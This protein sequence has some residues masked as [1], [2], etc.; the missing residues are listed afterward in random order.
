MLQWPVASLAAPRD[1]TVTWACRT[2]CAVSASTTIPAAVQFWPYVIPAV[3]EKHAATTAID[4][5]VE[6]RK[7]GET[8]RNGLRLPSETRSGHEIKWGQGLC[9]AAELPLGVRGFSLQKPAQAEPTGRCRSNDP[10]WRRDRLGACRRRYPCDPSWQ[11]RRRTR[12]RIETAPVRS[13]NRTSGPRRPGATVDGV[14]GPRMEPGG[15]V[16][17]WTH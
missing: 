5:P 4:M 10:P 11:T 8:F 17:S 13:G 6:F 15:F 7:P 16:R 1:C 9:F 12:P 3:N 14:S 2:G